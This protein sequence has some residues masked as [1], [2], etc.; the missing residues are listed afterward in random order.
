VSYDVGELREGIALLFL[1]AYGLGRR[2][3]RIVILAVEPWAEAEQ[4]VRAARARRHLALT[5]SHCDGHAAV[6]A[7]LA[8][9]RALPVVPVSTRRA[10]SCARYH[11]ARRARTAQAAQGCATPDRPV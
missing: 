10:E 8:A 9:L 2:H 11:A 6:A 4:V 5:P 3:K 7:R 1:E